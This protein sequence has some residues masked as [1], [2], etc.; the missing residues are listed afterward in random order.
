MSLPHWVFVKEK[1][2]FSTLHRLACVSLSVIACFS[3]GA[4]LI[5]CFRDTTIMSSLVFAEMGP[6]ARI[7]PLVAI[8]C[9]GTFVPLLA[10]EES[11]AM[12]VTCIAVGIVGF[13]MY[14]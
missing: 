3:F 4:F 2:M 1:V 11:R 10:R 6:I 9:A 8:A 12:Q 14:T 13:W 5:E 7:L